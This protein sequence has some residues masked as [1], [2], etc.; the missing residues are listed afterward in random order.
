MHAAITVQDLRK[1]YG[2][3]DTLV[4]AVDGVSFS[5]APGE[6]VVLLGA[7]GSGK[8][9]TLNL[10]GA[11]EQPTSGRLE[12]AGHNLAVL[13]EHGR[14]EYRRREVGFV[15]QLYN[16]V[17]SL[18]A[19][20]NVQLIAEITGPNGEQRALAALDRVG[21][22]DRATAFPGQL[23]G[24]QQQRVAIARAIVKQPAVLLCDEPTGALDL[25]HGREVLGVLSDLSRDGRTVVC[26]THNSAIARMATRVLR[27]SDGSIVDDAEQHDPLPA[28][29]LVW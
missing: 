26:V 4:H 11:I 16:L 25:D 6:F 10:I 14:T 17:P 27:L 8:T 18:T 15:F 2:S 23:S 9:T 21:I 13:D 1:T 24:G 29:E 22:A 20:E 12:V 5:V 19:L 3:G 28:Q 7:S